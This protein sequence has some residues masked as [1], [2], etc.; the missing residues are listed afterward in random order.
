MCFFFLLFIFLHSAC[1]K[2]RKSSTSE[3]LLQHKD[4][5]TNFSM[6]EEKEI[7]LQ[8]F[9]IRSGTACMSGPKNEICHLGRSLSIK[10]SVVKRHA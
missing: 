1:L 6:V 3:T 5:S 4:S 8:V 7:S 2:A 9:F 10:G